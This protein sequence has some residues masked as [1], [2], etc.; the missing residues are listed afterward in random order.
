MKHE[1]IIKR[2]EEAQEYF[3]EDYERN[4]SDYEFALGDQW[5][6]DIKSQ[7]SREGRP[8]LTENRLLPFINQVVNNIRQTRPQV[9][10]KPADKDADVD[11]AE[12]LEGLVRNIQN[13]NDAESCYDMA[14]FNAVAGGLGFIRI[15]TDYADYK[16]FDQE[17]KID[18]ILNPF[19]VLKLG[20]N[21]A[22]QNFKSLSLLFGE[23]PVKVLVLST[24]HFL[25][26]A[27]PLSAA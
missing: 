8:C 1:D 5:D 7:R 20:K 14:A 18:R 11:T 27:I 19:A 25:A 16:S 17:I 15:G 10:I 26:T 22:L 23:D 3:Q 4:R 12:V 21:V 6:D 9:V 2:F 13:Q 24:I